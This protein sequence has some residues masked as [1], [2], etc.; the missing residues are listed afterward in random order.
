MKQNKKV[1]RRRLKHQVNRCRGGL[2]WP[3]FEFISCTKQKTARVIVWF[4]DGLRERVLN[5][6]R[7]LNK[8]RTLD[9][10]PQR[11]E[12]KRGEKDSYSSGL[13]PSIKV[14]TTSSDTSTGRGPSVG[15]C[16]HWSPHPKD[17]T[18]RSQAF[19]ASQTSSEG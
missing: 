4:F 19:C 5:P 2:L 1:K 8:S 3:P 14:S 11:S 13:R 17:A 10:A 7:G 18:S 6:P 15:V 16:S 12:A 9:S